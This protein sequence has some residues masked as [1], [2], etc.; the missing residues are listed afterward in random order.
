MGQGILRSVQSLAQIIGP[1]WATTAVHPVLF[2]A[3]MLGF[4]ALSL[5]ILVAGWKQLLPKVHPNASQL[6]PTLLP[7]GEGILEV[8]AINSESASLVGAVA[9]ADGQVRSRAASRVIIN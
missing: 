1:V 6:E 7:P 4:T 2:W 5:V 3:G 9:G 8:V